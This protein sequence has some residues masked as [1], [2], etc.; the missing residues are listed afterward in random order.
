[1]TIYWMTLRKREDN[2][3]RKRK[4]YVAIHG[5]AAVEENTDLIVHDVTSQNRRSRQ[6]SLAFSTDR[7]LQAVGYLCPV[8]Q[9][10][11]YSEYSRTVRRLRADSVCSQPTYC[12]AVY[13]G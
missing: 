5:E 1:M 12:T 9:F 13:R 7:I 2:G 8:H 11:E 6:C 10:V 3:N 4:H